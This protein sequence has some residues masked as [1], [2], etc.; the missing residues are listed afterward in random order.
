M[1]LRLRRHEAP[2]TGKGTRQPD[3]IIQTTPPLILQ[4]TYAALAYLTLHKLIADMDRAG[5]LYDSPKAF[6]CG[7]M[8]DFF[9]FTGHR[10]RERPTRC[11][12][13]ICAAHSFRPQVMAS[14]SYTTPC[15]AR[16]YGR[17][18][19]AFL[20][21]M[22]PVETDISNQRSKISQCRLKRDIGSSGWESRQLSM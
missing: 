22:T 5:S 17:K 7:L 4:H 6:G 20:E 16:R 9:S 12:A 21:S 8:L 1:P 3:S 19:V 18:D 15:G 2:A 10:A 13:T 14:I 11:N